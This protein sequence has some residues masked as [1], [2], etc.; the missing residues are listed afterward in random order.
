[1]SNIITTAMAS[2]STHILNLLLNRL[3]VLSHVV[4]TFFFS[5]WCCSLAF[6]SCFALHYLRVYVL[7]IFLPCVVATTFSHYLNGMAKTY[8]LFSLLA[9][10]N[11]STELFLFL[12]FSC[13]LF[14][15]FIYVCRLFLFSVHIKLPVFYF[16]GLLI[17][18]LSF[19][20]SH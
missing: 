7:I 15:V 8:M 14:C 11:E 9:P 2:R 3:Q 13:R 10:S 19:F 1:M 12:L 5:L 6:G 18:Y 17:L 4:A 16:V 20:S